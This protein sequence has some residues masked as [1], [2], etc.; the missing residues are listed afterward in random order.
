[1][2]VAQRSTSVTGITGNGYN[3]ADR[4]TLTLSGLGTWTQSVEADGP[5]GSG[6]TKS[7]K[8]L[9]TTADN[10]P[11]AGDV[12]RVETYLEGQDLQRIKKG[13]SAAE[14]VT[15]SFWV[16]SNVTGTYVAFVYDEDGNRVCAQSYSV[17]ASATWE[18]KSI[19]LPADTTG[20]LNNDNGRSLFVS[21]VLGAGSNF[22][23]GTLQTTWGTY[24]AA[25]TAV[26]QTNL[27]AATNNYW[28][29]TGVQLETGP[30]ATP[31]EFEPFEAT[32]RKCQRY[33][34]KS[35]NPDV[36]PGTSTTVGL[37]GMFTQATQSYHFM[38]HRTLAPNM[39]AT[40]TVTVYSETGASGKIRNRTDNADV[41]GA[42]TFVGATGLVAYVNNSS[43]AGGKEIG[44]HFVAEIEL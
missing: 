33:Y 41:N 12:L 40:P 30:V 19:T 43:I 21:F 22:T 26:G 39:R 13:T 17:S 38:P 29:V 27:A 6:L 20:A 32:L 28:Q 34:Q 10:S 16:K 35:Y 42:A 37:V 9:C 3:T 31:F 7:L 24:S 1:M 11:A 18:K 8:M 36:N 4:W 23:S 25:N 2:Q 15:L 44:C 5:T 14:Q